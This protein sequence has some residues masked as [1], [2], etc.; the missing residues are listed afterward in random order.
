MIKGVLFIFLPLLG[1]EDRIYTG[2]DEVN[3]KTIDLDTYFSEKV[4][5]YFE[6]CLM[7]KYFYW[8]KN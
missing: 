6:H 1:V 2:K 8:N 3:A 4:P 5:F 7:V